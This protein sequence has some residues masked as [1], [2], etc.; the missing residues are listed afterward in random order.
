M[1]K[2]EG[3]KKPSNASRIKFRHLNCFLKILETGS[4]KGAAQ[5]LSVTESAASKTLRELESLLSI[6]LFERS[7]NGMS[8]TQAGA[9]FGTYARNSLE[10]LELGISES[11]KEGV[12]RRITLRIGAMPIASATFLPNVVQNFTARYPDCLVEISVGS[13]SSLLELLRK[14]AVELIVGRLP[15]AEDMAGFTFERIFM[16]QYIFVVRK[17]HA[18]ARR[19]SLHSEDLA[20]YPIL[21]PPKE[22][23]T[24]REIQRFFVASDF[25]PEGALIE[26][27]DVQFCKRYVL[28]SDAVWIAS[29]RY[30]HTESK[31]E[32]LVRLPLVST[33]L[34]APVGLIKRARTEASLHSRHF[35]ALARE[36]AEP[37]APNSSAG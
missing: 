2:H 16:D 23:V 1:T 27:L 7:N 14:G 13:K 30:L 8:A 19:R 18:L 17:G 26:T 15:L 25:K 4:L 35:L 34:E 31:A 20:P 21:M 9:V 29:E 11:H 5:A 28:R 32:H 3:P 10:A 37:L 22:T 6:R 33:L 24:W 36:A 12:I